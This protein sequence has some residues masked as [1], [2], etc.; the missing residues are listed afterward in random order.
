MQQWEPLREKRRGHW[1][2]TSRARQ[3]W[4]AEALT[5]GEE[6]PDPDVLPTH[7]SAVLKARLRDCPIASGFTS[8]PHLGL[9]LLVLLSS[10]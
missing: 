5:K 8:V 9:L 4:L 3:P 2:G 1:D 7:L 6:V 10:P